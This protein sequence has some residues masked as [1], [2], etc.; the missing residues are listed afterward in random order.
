MI[1]IPEI[2]EQ[3]LIWVPVFELI[4]DK[5]VCRYWKLL[6]EISLPLRYYTRTG[7]RPQ[8]E[9]L[10]KIPEVIIDDK[11]CKITP[12]GWKVIS[13]AW[14]KL[15]GTC[16]SWPLPGSDTL[17]GSEV[18]IIEI[19]RAIKDVLEIYLPLSEQIQLYSVPKNAGAYGYPV[20]LRVDQI[21]TNWAPLPCSGHDKDIYNDFMTTLGNASKGYGQ[22][23]AFAQILR[24]LIDSVYFGTPTGFR[25]QYTVGTQFMRAN[26]PAF[27]HMAVG[28]WSRFGSA[29]PTREVLPSLNNGRSG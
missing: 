17:V 10:A 26:Q 28:F 6:I 5:R 13:G 11:D 2:L 25:L 19:Q 4:V 7:V 16:H 27:F 15:A 29:E 14:R 1:Y 24:E 22:L 12:I 8:T 9:S 3:I 18:H 23:S 21:T 20:F